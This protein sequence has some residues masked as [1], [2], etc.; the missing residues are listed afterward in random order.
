MENGRARGLLVEAG[1][2]LVEV[3]ARAIVATAGALNTPRLLRGLG[4]RSRNLGRHLHIHPAVGV[5]GVMPY[6]V[7][8]WV[9][10]CSHTT[11]TIS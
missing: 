4:M 1:G 2:T 7:R 9:E 3:E 8:G 6:P 11:W 5:A 10:Q